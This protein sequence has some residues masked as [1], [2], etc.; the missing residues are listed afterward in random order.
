VDGTGPRPVS[1]SIAG[2]R[3]AA[4]GDIRASIGHLARPLSP[5]HGE[6]P[7]DEVGLVQGRGVGHLAV[8]L[9]EPAAT[10]P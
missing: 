3:A 5:C 10:G 2:L 1:I 9:E 7:L 8:V 6:V 4:G